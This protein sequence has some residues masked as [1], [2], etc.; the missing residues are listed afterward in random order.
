MKISIGEFLQKVSSIG[1]HLNTED[2]DRLLE[3][4]FVS[5]NTTEIVITCDLTFLKDRRKK[6]SEVVNYY[7]EENQKSMNDAKQYQT[8]RE[9]LERLRGVDPEYFKSLFENAKFELGN[10][11]PEYDNVDFENVK[12]FKT[13]AIVF[14]MMKN[15][16]ADKKSGKW[17]EP[18]SPKKS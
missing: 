12:C 17:R 4:L 15:F 1:D 7:K 5:Y 18:C 3:S 6:S 16:F 2:I 9:S 8:Y 14:E 13:T 10:I 11:S